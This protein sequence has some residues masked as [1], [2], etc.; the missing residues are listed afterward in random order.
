MGIVPKCECV[1]RRANASHSI[2]NK[3]NSLIAKSLERTTSCLHS[4]LS[5][6]SYS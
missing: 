5:I 6:N 2:H 4:D 3:L 1:V